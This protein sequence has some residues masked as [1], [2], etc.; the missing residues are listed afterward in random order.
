MTV[1]SA[2]RILHEEVVP[3]Q[4]L[5][6]RRVPG[7]NNRQLAAG[8]GQYVNDLALDGMTHL[9]FLRSPYA[10]ARILGIDATAA[11]ARPGVLLVLTG[12]DVLETLRPI[13]GGWDA[14]KMGAKSVTW[15]ALV[16]DRVRY[17]G[18]LVAAV[19][20]EDRWTANAALDDVVVDYEELPAVTDPFEALASDARLVEPDWG[21]N[22]QVRRRFGIGDTDAA[23]AVA[24]SIASGHVGMERITGVP[25]EPR[26][27]VA[28]YDPF[29][30]RLTYWDSTQNPHPLRTILAE[31]LGMPEG[32][33]RVIQP[34]VGGAFGLKQPPFQEEPVLA[35]A[36]RRLGRPV[37]WIE[38]RAENFMATGHARAFE[39]DYRV[40]FD[41]DGVIDAIA[42][43]ALA[44]VGAPTSLVGWGMTFA[45]T[46]VIPS[47]YDIPN[48]RV[49]LDVVVTNTCPWNAYRGFG[50]DAGAFL[51]DR[52]IEHVAR[53]TGLPSEAVRRRNLIA[54]DTFP[55]PMPSGGMLDSG[56][57]AGVLDRLLAAIDEPAFRAEQAAA[58]GGRP[59]ARA[60]P[61]PGADARG[62][63]PSRGR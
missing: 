48:V 44:D 35:E 17:V 53:E 7:R 31:T 20:A 60:G 58:L 19:V 49:E 46:N 26:G 39:W 57:Y 5:I 50:K 23:F 32:S 1:T 62:R 15:R 3:P 37:K 38:E 29:S 11:L 33:V 12:R 22:V 59:P 34:H 36:S 45:A 25:I 24:T 9:A 52:V 30:G 40:A 55:R 14:A 10:H 54:A 8:R 47:V 43:R 4:G 41:A 16:P 6:G 63:A 28:Q 2:P 27:I 42:V 13:P 18:E 51:M 61:R 56:D 21:E